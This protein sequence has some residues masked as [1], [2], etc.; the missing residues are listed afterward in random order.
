[1]YQLILDASILAGHFWNDK[2]GQNLKSYNIFK[3]KMLK[4][5]FFL[6]F[7]NR[8]FFPQQ[9]LWSSYFNG[10]STHFGLLYVK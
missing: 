4:L 7:H 8:I 3:L 2:R 6:T 1:M 10:I 9:I 5:L